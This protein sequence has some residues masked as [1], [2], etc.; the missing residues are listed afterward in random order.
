MGASSWAW[1]PAGSSQTFA[2]S[3]FPLTTAPAA[4]RRRC[5]SWCHCC[6]RAA[7]TSRVRTIR[8]ASANYGREGRHREVL[9]CG[10]RVMARGCARRWHATRMGFHR[11]AAHPRGGRGGVRPLDAACYSIGRDPATLRRA[12]F[13]LGVTIVPLDGSAP[14]GSPEESAGRLRTLCETVGAQSVVLQ[15]AG[16]DHLERL[17][18]VIEALRQGPLSRP[19]AT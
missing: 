17:I 9:R 6:A 11:V 18:P 16:P 15:V 1:R 12:A 7:S 3:A 8:H 10:S 13:A 19:T 2:P 4:S 14:S 5:R